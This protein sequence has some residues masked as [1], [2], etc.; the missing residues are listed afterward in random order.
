MARDVAVDERAERQHPHA[1]RT[2]LV[3]G[4]RDQLR[5]QSLT[6]EARVDLGVDERDQVLAAAVLHEAGDL[7]ADANLIAF[8]A[9]IVSDHPL[10]PTHRRPY[11]DGVNILGPRAAGRKRPLL[12]A[13]GA[14][15]ALALAAPQARAAC[16]AQPLGQT[17]LPWIDLAYYQPA[18]DSGFE[19]GGS[20]SLAGGAS[21]VEANDPYL[22]GQ[23]ALDLPAG[24]TATTAPICVTVAHPTLRFFA[25]NT[26]SS[27]APLTVT[28]QFRTLLGV[29]LE[30]PV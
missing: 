25:R 24:A 26:G 9:R 5:A 17:F 21:T 20:W 30:V 16:P 13:A 10:D 14:L 4:A 22:P 19:N 8:L 1:G 29:V 28:V 3:Q 18:P 11:F 7:V 15:A 12:V 27:L 23:N 2:G 6:L